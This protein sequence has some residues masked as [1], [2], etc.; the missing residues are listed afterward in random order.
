MAVTH[1]RPGAPI[2]IR[3]LRVEPI[4]RYLID[5]LRLLTRHHSFVPTDENI[6][7]ATLP[8]DVDA[9]T[10]SFLPCA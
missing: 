8:V 10:N 6:D 7:L 1:G 4:F 9:H 3:F 2:L 5:I